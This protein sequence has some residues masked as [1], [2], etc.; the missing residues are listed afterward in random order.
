[1]D[2]KEL[3]KWTKR[4][5][6]KSKIVGDVIEKFTMVEEGL[7]LIINH[8]FAPYYYSRRVSIEFEKYILQKHFTFE[9]KLR[10]LRRLKFE[11]RKELKFDKKIYNDL[12][13]LQE[14][15]NALAHMTSIFGIGKEIPSLEY[16]HDGKS[17]T[18][19][20]NEKFQQKFIERA[21]TTTLNLNKLIH[22]LDI[23]KKKKK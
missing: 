23:M 11:E 22:K 12:E 2:K 14:Q 18:I 16:F 4:F 5:D 3:K 1:M 8:Y 17:K 6:K 7:N 13:W 21:W 20:I 19:E 10:I 9:I 15:R